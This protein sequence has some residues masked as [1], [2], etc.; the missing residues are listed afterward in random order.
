MVTDL[1]RLA[2]KRNAS[3]QELALLETLHTAAKPSV[4]PKLGMTKTKGRLRAT[5]QRI[6]LDIAG[7]TEAVA[8]TLPNED[9][10]VYMVRYTISKGGSFASLK[11]I[12]STRSRGSL[13]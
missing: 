12:V 8:E 6:L 7:R 3:A 4:W 10:L 5:Y 2:C 1:K 13:V 11:R 9:Q